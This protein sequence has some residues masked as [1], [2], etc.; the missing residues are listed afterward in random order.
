MIEAVGHE[1]LPAYFRAISGFLKPGGQAVI[2]VCI[3]LCMPH[4]LSGVHSCDGCD[5]PLKALL[6]DLPSIGNVSQHNCSIEVIGCC[7]SV[8]CAR[9]LYLYQKYPCC[10]LSAVNISSGPVRAG[11]IRAGRAL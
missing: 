2:Q 4:L 3:R 5:C 7:M 8:S 6:Q 1:N 9:S 10:R 11:H